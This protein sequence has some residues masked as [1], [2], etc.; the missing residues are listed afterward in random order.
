VIRHFAANDSVFVDDEYLIKG[1]AGAKLAR[2]LRLVEV[3]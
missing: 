3:S 2:P 1:V